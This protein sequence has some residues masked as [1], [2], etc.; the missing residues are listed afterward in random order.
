MKNLINAWKKLSL[1]KQIIIGLVIG[2]A[3][4]LT[5]PEQAKFVVIFGSLFVGAL[6]ALAPVL[7]FF[8]VS[9]A[10]AQHKSGHKTNM[11]A[12]VVLYVRNIPGWCCRCSCKLYVPNKVDTSIRS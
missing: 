4:A 7:V 10:L 6:K 12:I 5:I 2:I 8:L 1:V 9:S 11:K 3:L